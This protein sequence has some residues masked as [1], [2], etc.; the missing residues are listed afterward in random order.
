M[1]YNEKNKY[2]RKVLTALL[3]NSVNLEMIGSVDT[4]RNGIQRNYYLNFVSRV[5]DCTIRSLLAKSKADLL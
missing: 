5:T 2:K 1:Q 3:P 4:M